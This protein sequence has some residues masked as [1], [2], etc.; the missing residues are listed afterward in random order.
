[1]SEA[2]APKPRRNVEHTPDGAPRN[3]TGARFR[4]RIDALGRIVPLVVPVGAE[5]RDAQH[6]E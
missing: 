5:G 1:M 6:D 4:I 3:R 2:R